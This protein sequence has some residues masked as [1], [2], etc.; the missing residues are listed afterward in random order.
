MEQT[1]KF[2]IPIIRSEQRWQREGNSFFKKKKINNKKKKKKRL[3]ERLEIKIQPRPDL[4]L[5]T[6]K[7]KSPTIIVVEF[8]IVSRLP[9]SEGFSLSEEGRM[10]GE[11]KKGK[12][13]EKEEKRSRTVE[14]AKRTEEMQKGGERW[15]PVNGG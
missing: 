7:A 6:I 5:T 15:S 4:L 3:A 10:K 1:T 8:P 11:K 9:L 2:V 13:R 12:E 14:T